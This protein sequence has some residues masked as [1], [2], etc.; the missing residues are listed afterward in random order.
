MIK[1]L[2]DKCGAEKPRHEL[3]RIF[4]RVLKHSDMGEGAVFDSEV[5]DYC[6]TTM[7]NQ[8]RNFVFDFQG[9]FH[10]DT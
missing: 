10:K 6:R 9:T 7:V 5:C 2:C 3:Y 4:T 8:L 1:H